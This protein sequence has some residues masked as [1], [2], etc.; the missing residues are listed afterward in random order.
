MSDEYDR[1]R[2]PFDNPARGRIFENGIEHLFLD[3]QSGYV[4]QPDRYATSLGPRHYDKARA[5]EHGRIH[6]IEDKSGQVGS[7]NDVRELRK[8]REL[9]AK[10]EIESLRI[11][12]V[13]GEQMSPKYRQLLIDLKQ[14]FG[15]RVIH[16]ELT[17]DQARAAFAKGLVHEKDAR[18]LELKTRYELDRANRAR[19]RLA[20]IREIMRARE[21]AE[22]FRKMQQFREAATRGRAEAPHRAERARQAREQAERARQARET[23][24]TERA[25]VEREAA[26]R[27]AREFPLSNQFQEREAADAGEQA[28]RETAAV[29]REA[30][31]RARAATDKERDACKA[32]INK[33]AARDAAFKELDAKG[34]LSEVERLL[35]LGQATHPQAAVREPPGYGPQVERGG[36]GQGQD[37]PRGLMR[38]R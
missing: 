25:R 2:E 20:R 10:R 22:Q 28:A 9:L 5:D 12:T 23:P 4:Q 14:E 3:L 38:D 30:A 8:D 6:A 21:R 35:W 36:T 1:I 15:D 16:Q 18:Q 17:R 27:V 13:A 11:R 34:R 33:D 7:K 19:Q 24:G 37:R 29:E 31:D 26:E 32:A